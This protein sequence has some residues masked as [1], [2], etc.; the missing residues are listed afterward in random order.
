MSSD[1]KA[2]ILQMQGLCKAKDGHWE[3]IGAMSQ[4]GATPCMNWRGKT[5]LVRRALLKLKGIDMNGKRAT[6]KCGNPL[7]VN[8]EHIITMTPSELRLRD[9]EKR[10]RD[11]LWRAAISQGRRKNGKL[12]DEMVAGIRAD[13]RPQRQIAATYGIAQ[14]TVSSIRR[15]VKLVNYLNPIA[16]HVARRGM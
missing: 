2:F 3:W 10:P 1:L 11:V 9:A 12:T 4:P 8:P 16:A 6:Y 5:V 15:G 13:N 14:A 7:C